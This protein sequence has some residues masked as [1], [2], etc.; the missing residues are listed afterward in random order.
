MTSI[1]IDEATAVRY[2]DID[3][4]VGILFIDKTLNHKKTKL[5]SCQT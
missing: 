2:K 4:K 5:Q 3:L 1:R